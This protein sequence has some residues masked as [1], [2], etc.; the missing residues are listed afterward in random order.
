MATNPLINSCSS[1]SLHLITE[2]N[3]VDSSFHPLELIQPVPEGSQEGAVAS[4]DTRANLRDEILE[5]GCLT[6]AIRAVG[7]VAGEVIAGGFA[8]IRGAVVCSPAGRAAG[9]TPSGRDVT[10]V[11]HRVSGWNGGPP[12]VRLGRDAESRGCCPTRD[13]ESRG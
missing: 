5:R 7:P 13:T 8:P 1:E 3:F 11:S 2:L 12:G 10:S 9:F 4:R 6:G